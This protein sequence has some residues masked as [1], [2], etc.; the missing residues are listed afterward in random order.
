MSQNIENVDLVCTK[1]SSDL[2]NGKTAF[3][4][5]TFKE[6]ISQAIVSDFL[7][8]LKNSQVNPNGT[9]EH[10][11]FLQPHCYSD[12]KSSFPYGVRID[13]EWTFYEYDDGVYNPIQFYPDRV[14]NEIID[15]NNE[16]EYNKA[17]ELIRKQ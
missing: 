11:I 12:K 6:T 1:S 16:N 14:L 10:R 2:I 5:L 15:H 3:P 9:K 7:F 8:N 13:R 4:K 17:V